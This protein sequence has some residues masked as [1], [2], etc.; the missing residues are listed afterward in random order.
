[1]KLIPLYGRNGIGKFTQVDDEDYDYLIQWR[2]FCIY[3]EKSSNYYIVRNPTKDLKL[4][5]MHTIIMGKKE[6][7]VI[8]HIDGDSL[9]NQKSNLRHCT[10]IENGQNKRNKSNSLSKYK[11]VGKQRNRY[12]ARIQKDK[13]P[14]YI[15]T[16]NT[17]EEAAIAYNEKAKELFGEFAQLNCLNGGTKQG[18]PNPPKHIVLRK[19][20]P[21]FNGELP[22]KSKAIPLTNGKFTIVSEEDYE[23]LSQYKWLSIKKSNAYFMA[24]KNG[25]RLG[26]GR[27]EPRISMH[28]FIM[29]PKKGMVVDHINRNPLDNRRENLRVVTE[30]VNANNRTGS[31]RNPKYYIQLKCL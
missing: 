26:G 31:L 24:E 21:V 12:S 4:T 2:W 7:L 11:G 5:K 25:K 29:K 14:I 18:I 15:G 27:R 16:F 3:Q 6:G 30:K 19:E 13:T 23:W 17:E 28:R 1:M 22:P 8:D 9:N 20:P 10:H